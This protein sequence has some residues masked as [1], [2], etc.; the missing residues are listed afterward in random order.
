MYSLVFSD[1]MAWLTCDMTKYTFSS[2]FTYMYHISGLEIKC[3]I[4]IHK[5]VIDL[6]MRGY[7]SPASR[8]SELKKNSQKKEACGS[9]TRRRKAWSL[10][11]NFCCICVIYKR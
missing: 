8:H 4:P 5:N 9:Q 1:P 7:P 6:N 11:V 10:N 2:F 3:Y